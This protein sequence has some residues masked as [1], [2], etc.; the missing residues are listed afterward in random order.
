MV[1]FT[2]QALSDMGICAAIFL[3]AAVYYLIYLRPRQATHW[4]MLDPTHDNEVELVVT[5]AG[6][7]ASTSI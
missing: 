2:R 7:Q 4:V 3:V 6:P 5:E 1:V